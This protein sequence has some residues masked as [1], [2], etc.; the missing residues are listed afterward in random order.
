MPRCV[1]SMPSSLFCSGGAKANLDRRC[2]RTGSSGGCDS[3]V[4]KVLRP[5]SVVPLTRRGDLVVQYLQFVEHGAPQSFLMI[6]ILV[7]RGGV[8]SQR[9][10]PTL[11][12]P[13]CRSSGTT[14]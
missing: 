14:S 10:A 4:P 2:S 3:T 9:V 5:L 11:P 7:P 12:C 6:C 1:C 13:C 8:R